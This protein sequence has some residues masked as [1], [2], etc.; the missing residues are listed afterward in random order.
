L[1]KSLGL[2]LLWALGSL[3]PAH[4]APFTISGTLVYNQTLTELLPDTFTLSVTGDTSPGWLA[5]GS[6]NF[7]LG[8]SGA[9]TVFFDPGIDGSTLAQPYNHKGF[10]AGSSLASSISSGSL[11][12]ESLS[13]EGISPLSVSAT[14]SGL[15]LG[16]NYVVNRD[17]DRKNGS[18]I[19]PT[20]L[21][22]SLTTLAYSGVTP[23]SWSASTFTLALSP[24][25]T[26]LVP[27]GRT[28][29][30]FGP[31]LYGPP[32]ITTATLPALG[33]LVSTAT[34]SWSQ[35]VNVVPEPGSYAL[36][37]SG[38]AALLALRR[39]R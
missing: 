4:A 14:F 26:A 31:V 29:G 18:A 35:T 24:V 21:A 7:T 32:V 1:K 39:R 8:G 6:A 22:N 37:A 25:L 33:T 38:L 36:L 17:V 5:L 20:N 13:G 19:G 11:L 3:V 2:A 34:Y 15:S 12:T 9:G 16:G 28:I 23:A 10:G 27:P 30:S